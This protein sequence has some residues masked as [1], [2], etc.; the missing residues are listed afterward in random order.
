[1][2]TRT[3]REGQAGSLSRPER[4]A[5]GGTLVLGAL[6]C[7][8]GVLCL[9]A[10]GLATVAAIYYIGA[11]L[12]IAGVISLAY[13]IR[14]A[15][16]GVVL[17]GV[18]SLVVGVLMFTHP[19]SGM[20]ALTLLLIG[21]FWIT[22]LYRVVTSVADRYQGWGMDCLSGLCSIAIGAIAARSWPSS[23][24]WLLGTLVGADFFIRG[25]FTMAAAVTAR[26]AMRT[27]RASNV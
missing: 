1:M 17:M 26:R 7:I 5:W 16:G 14:G 23:A 15:G 13:G 3:D 22:G 19:G 8:A 20:A 12:A 18:L 21:Y 10:S 4:A 9:A 11:L 24:M 27:L 2:P 25:V 6:W